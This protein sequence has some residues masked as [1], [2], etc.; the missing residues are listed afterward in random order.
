MDARLPSKFFHFHAVFE[1]NRM[2][3]PAPHP[4][5]LAPLQGLFVPFA[6][7]G[8]DDPVRV[9]RLYTT[10]TLDTIETFIAE[11]MYNLSL[12]IL[13]CYLLKSG[14]SETSYSDGC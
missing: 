13:V 2:L 6:C 7:V 8:S 1:Q 5:E 4:G 3:A 12:P 9:L 10:N 11:T 14:D